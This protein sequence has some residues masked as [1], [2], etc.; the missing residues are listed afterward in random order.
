V[1]V[2]VVREGEDGLL[3][4]PVPLHRD[5]DV[6]LLLGVPVEVDDL[7]AER[8][9]AVV[10]VADEVL[11][12]ALGVELGEL[13]L[14]ALV[15]DRDAQAAGEERRLAQAL[16]ER[17]VVEVDDLEDLR[18]REEGDRRAVPVGR[19]ALRISDWRRP[20]RYSWRQTCRRGGSRPAT[21]PRAR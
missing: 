20:P 18:V 17:R 7:L 14:A 10:E 16:L 5:L 6:A 13:P 1:R 2:D 12:A 9:L 3:V 8:L 21:T 15:L 4:G 11:D 19:L